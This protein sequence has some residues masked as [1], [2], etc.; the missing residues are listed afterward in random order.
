MP[1]ILTLLPSLFSFSWKD[2]S[3]HTVHVWQLRQHISGRKLYSGV[4]L[5]ATSLHFPSLQTRSAELKDCH[6]LNIQHRSLLCRKTAEVTTI[7][8][9][10]NR[11]EP[12]PCLY[13]HMEGWF[14]HLY[15][16]YLY[17]MYDYDY[18]YLIGLGKMTT[19]CWYWYQNQL[20]QYTF[21]FISTND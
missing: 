15:F 1:A 6:T 11:P 21:T 12:S 14:I 2:V 17:K 13:K 3:D 19:Y 16:I 4:I 10:V 20:Y 5:S 7:T 9:L 18:D 8:Q